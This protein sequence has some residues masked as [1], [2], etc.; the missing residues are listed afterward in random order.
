[1]AIVRLYLMWM[2]RY[3]TG[4]IAR[5]KLLVVQS[6]RRLT[7]PCT[8][9]TRVPPS[10]FVSRTVRILQDITSRNSPIRIGGP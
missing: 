8:G 10:Y 7:V 5:L 4:V 9:P 2:T 1:M 3:P 6:L